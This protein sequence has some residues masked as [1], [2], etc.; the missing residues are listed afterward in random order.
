M[1]AFSPDHPAIPLIAAGALVV[2]VHLI[3]TASAII[4]RRYRT[5]GTVLYARRP[6][7]FLICA[8][9]LEVVV[10]LPAFVRFDG[11]TIW[12]LAPFAFL[13]AGGF[14]QFVPTAL[15]VW[16]AEHD[17]LTS[18]VLVWRRTLPWDAIDWAFIRERRTEQTWNELKLLESKDRFLYVEAGPKRRMKIPISTWLAG[19]A[20]P[21]MRAIEARATN[22]YFG[23]EKR[24]DVERQRDVR[25][26]TL[27]SPRGGGD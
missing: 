22:A 24:V 11:D 21:L 18:Q 23:A 15:R 7:V 26:P 1:S 27:P 2:V 16:A 8:G 17:G 25:A 6:I 3:L 5:V 12:V 14:L 10:A 13:A 20:T 9:A 4:R 19:D